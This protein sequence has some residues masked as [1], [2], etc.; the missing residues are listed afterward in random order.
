MEVTN[1]FYVNGVKL[2]K[3]KAEDSEIEPYLLCL[4]NILKYFTVEKL[5]KLD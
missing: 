2:C 5:K 3:F 1:F 4:G